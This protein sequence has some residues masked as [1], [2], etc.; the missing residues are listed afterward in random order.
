[1]REWVAGC[2]VTQC[3]GTMPSLGRNSGGDS[4]DY[5][6]FTV[7]VSHMVILRPWGVMSFGSGFWDACKLG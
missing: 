1:M 3:M 2:I 5:V 4:D 7:F 6:G